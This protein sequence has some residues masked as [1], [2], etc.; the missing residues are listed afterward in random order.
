MS[1]PLAAIA[2]EATR[3]CV[4]ARHPARAPGLFGVQALAAWCAPDCLCADVDHLA[5]VLTKGCRG[6]S[7]EGL[8]LSV[9]PR[10]VTL[11]RRADSASP[12]LTHEIAACSELPRGACRISRTLTSDV[13]AGAGGPQ[14]VTHALLNWLAVERLPPW[15]SSCSSRADG[16]AAVGLAARMAW[17]ASL[18]SD[19]LAGP[20][21]TIA[22]R[23]LETWLEAG[24]AGVAFLTDVAGVRSEPWR[25]RLRYAAEWL[26]AEVD[27]CLAPMLEGLGRRRAP[28]A[29]EQMDRAVAMHTRFLECLTAGVVR[30]L[31]LP[32]ASGQALGG[33]WND[34]LSPMG[35][36]ELIYL[37]RAGTPALRTLAALRLM[38][39]EHPVA[40]AALRQMLTSPWWPQVVAGSVAM[41][42]RGPAASRSLA[43]AALAVAQE[44][45][46]RPI[47]RSIILMG[48]L[49][50]AGADPDTVQACL[51]ALPDGAPANSYAEA[52]LAAGSIPR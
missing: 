35:R 47:D 4:Q 31:E 48:A 39:D 9:E 10:R 34:P 20:R 42:R 41:G 8:M 33:A 18:R 24:R 19:G 36:S 37:C 13:C 30:M 51:D 14:A 43:S 21:L 44:E 40:E 17:A 52:R 2:A 11:L 7:T 12:S 15:P 25:V 50:D 5:W 38:D 6:Y 26:S 45:P 32:G 29:A 23:R 22:R 46:E 49:C 1:A 3:H 28:D 16:Q 27:E